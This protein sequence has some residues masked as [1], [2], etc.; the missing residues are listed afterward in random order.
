MPRTPEEKIRANAQLVVDRLS[1]VS[2]LDTRFGYN[3]DSVKW[4]YGFI[5]RRR[6]AADVHSEETAKLIQVLGSYL[7]EC[8]IHTYGGIWKE[9]DD[10]WV[11]SFD[12]SN[13]VFPFNKVWKQFHYGH[14]DS[15]LSFFE[16]IPVVFKKP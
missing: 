8:V 13:H 7:G 3:R 16:M 10:Q 9:Q 5:E 14:G 11:V 1:S 4:V 12:D 15:I 6:T 2:G